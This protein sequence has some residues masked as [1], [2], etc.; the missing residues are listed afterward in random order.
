M[1]MVVVIRLVVF[2]FRENYANF[3]WANVCPGNWKYVGVVNVQR[4]F[5]REEEGYDGKGVF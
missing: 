5:K 4:S 1:C 2:C 3:I